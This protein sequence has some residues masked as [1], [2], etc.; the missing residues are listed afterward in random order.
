MRD[1]FVQTFKDNKPEPNF[2]D[3]TVQGENKIR[4]LRGYK[5]ILFL[6]KF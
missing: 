2:G 1:T 5:S 4:I 3:E 6:I